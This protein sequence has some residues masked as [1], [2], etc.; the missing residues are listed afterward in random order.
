MNRH[1]LYN[2]LLAAGVTEG[3]A[4]D[5][6]KSLDIAPAAE[7]T[8]DVDRLSK[9]LEDI[10]ETFE[11]DNDGAE[12]LSKAM[13]EA[14]DIVEAVTR[15]ADALLDEV[16]KQNAVL[17]KGLL[18]FGEKL[19]AI[20]G[21]ITGNGVA[22]AKSLTSVASELAAPGQPRAVI[23]EATVIPAPGESQ[24]MSHQ[25]LISKAI[26]ELRTADDSHR[27]SELRKAVTLLESGASAHDVATNYNLR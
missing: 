2:R 24:G 8:V 25:E 11:S 13:N 23:G 3:E 21:K 4:K 19:V 9:A 12:D 20:E 26:T 16:R 10:K 27:V 15:G 1:D 18:T 5:I 7:E 17:A 22:I 6:A 14:G